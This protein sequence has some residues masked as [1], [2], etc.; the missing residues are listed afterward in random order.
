MADRGNPAPDHLFKLVII[1]DAGV[2]KSS[3]LLRFTEDNF[4]TN[5]ISTIGVD[6]RF[7]T[8]NIK[9]K[10]VKLQIWDT[11]G[12]ERFRTITSAYYRGADGVILVY[13]VTNRDSFGH[14]EDWL[15]QVNKYASEDTAKL[16]VGNKADLI[17]DKKVNSE[18]ALAMGEKHGIHVI[19][20][21]AKTADNVDMAFNRLGEKLIETRGDVAEKKRVEGRVKLKHVKTGGSRKCCK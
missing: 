6:F 15:E 21:S 10:I 3:L 1:G 20:T 19:E 17:E 8:L 11:A 12:Q 9:K 16:I 2:G 18:E 13:D 4:S 7:R 14:V 5:Y